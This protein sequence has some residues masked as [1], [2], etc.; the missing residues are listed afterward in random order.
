MPMSE[1]NGTQEAA[2]WTQLSAYVADQLW[3]GRSTPQVVRELQDR[4][5]DHATAVAFVEAIE[6]RLR[7]GGAL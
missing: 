2:R 3:A 1:G 6:A 7:Q 4:G 5:L